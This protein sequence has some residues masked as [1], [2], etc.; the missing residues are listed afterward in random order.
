[1]KM[2]ET[3]K[4]YLYDTPIAA[5]I[6]CTSLEIN[7][8][9][10]NLFKFWWCCWM[11]NRNPYGMYRA[12]PFNKLKIGGIVHSIKQSF[13]TKTENTMALPQKLDIRGSSI[14][15]CGFFRSIFVFFFFFFIS[16]LFIYLFIFAFLFFKCVI[17]VCRWAIYEFWWTLFVG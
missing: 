2:N 9:L 17:L 11:L 1:M 13:T 4:T 6:V 8:N 5:I 10:S 12:R 15:F 14:S 7:S 16:K 3:G